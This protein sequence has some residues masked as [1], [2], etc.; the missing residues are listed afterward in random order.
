M[1][2]PNAKV[3]RLFEA[4]WQP[5][6]LCSPRR[7]TAAPTSAPYGYAVRCLQSSF[8]DV[9]RLQLVAG[10]NLPPLTVAE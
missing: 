3:C 7:C 6:S 9:A 5:R 1:T 2:A 4:T 10:E 8:F